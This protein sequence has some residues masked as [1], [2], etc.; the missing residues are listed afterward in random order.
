MVNLLVYIVS[1]LMTYIF[2]LLNKKL[3]VNE[4]MP[5]PIQNIIVGILVFSIFYI[6]F[7]PENKEE[8][9]EQIVMAL[10]GSGTATLGYDTQKLKKEE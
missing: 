1:T 9:I 8:V 5:I 7:K 10:G 6:F 4:I 2:G 3:K